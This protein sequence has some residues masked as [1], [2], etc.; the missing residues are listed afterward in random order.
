ME[1]HSLPLV[2]VGI[3]TFNRASSLVT[4][5]ESVLKQTYSNIELVI[6]DNASTDNTQSICENFCKNDVRITYIRQESNLGA[7]NNFIEVLKHSTGEYFM[8]LGDDDWIDN[9]YVAE[10]TEILIDHLD[11]S[12]ICGKCKYYIDK[13]FFR[14][15]DIINIDEDNQCS[16]LLSYY[17][18][19]SDN[20]TFYGIMRTNQ[21]SNIPIKNTMGGDWF[22]I[23]AI[24]FLGKVKTIP[25][26]VIY[27]QARQNDSLIEL[28]TR[29]NLSEFQKQQPF[30]SIAFSACKDI[31]T[32]KN[33]SP[34]NF[35]DKI[36]LSMNIFKIFK[37]KYPLFL[38]RDYIFLFARKYLPAR[39]YLYTQDVYRRLIKQTKI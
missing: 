25:T 1:N 33:Y 5:I 12:L 30:L 3:P 21:I 26:T 36:Y 4:A 16:R 20:G 8:W 7:T 22:V 18:Q 29:L 31:I 15:G 11:H 6:S 32:N 13:E 28:A 23:A 17:K 35:M 19:V 38:F 39:I 2:S 9:N 10:C 27:R 14:Q 37:E 34:L 24:S